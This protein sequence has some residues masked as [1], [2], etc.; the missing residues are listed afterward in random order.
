MYLKEHPEAANEIEENIR[1]VKGVIQG[2]ENVDSDA[3]DT[4]TEEESVSV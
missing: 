4:P 3:A 1:K 2:E